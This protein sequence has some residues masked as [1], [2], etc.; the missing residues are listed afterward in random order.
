M[1]LEQLGY[2]YLDQYKILKQKTALLRKRIRGGVS[3]VYEA[4][5]KLA[6]LYSM[7]RD[8][9]ETGEYL[10]NYHKYRS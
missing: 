10:I 2:E 4:Q 9:K 3:D 7:A 8:C 1:T 6:M 5:T